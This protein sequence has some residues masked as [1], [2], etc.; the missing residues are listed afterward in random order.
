MLFLSVSSLAHADTLLIA[1]ASNF[2]APA[3]ELVQEFAQRTGHDVRISSAST[4][5]L[6]AQITNGAPYDVFL[7]ADS[8]HPRLLEDAGLGVSG[9]RVSYALG[10]LVLWSR[11][12]DFVNGGCRE[13]LDNL[14]DR[15]LAI[16]NPDIA[17]YGAAARQF[18]IRAG[19]WTEVN[20]RLVYGESIAQALHFV[21]TGNAQLGVIAR[22]Q[23]LDARLPAGT[24]TW[25]VPAELHDPIEQQ[26]VVL[27]RAAG[28]AAAAAFIDYLAGAAAADIVRRFGYGAPE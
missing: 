20:R 8:E 13:A 11:H 4:G 24:C 7:A 23:V 5:K 21:A 15:H 27:Q 6:Y 16:A 22:S 17:P 19:L 26:A 14:G 10:A 2:R 9:T 3:D 25:P 18:L 12:S 1:V 28:N